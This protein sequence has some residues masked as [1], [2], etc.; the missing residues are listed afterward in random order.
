MT[1]GPNLEASVYLTDS[2]NCRLGVCAHELRHLVFQW[3]DFYDA[4]YDED[5]QYWDGSGA[6]DLM[7]GGSYDGDSQRPAHP[8]GLHEMQHGWR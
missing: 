8:A 7:A 2:Q 1:A 4:N 3:D 6:W 5:G